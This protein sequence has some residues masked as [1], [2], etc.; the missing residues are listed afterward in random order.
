MTDY[1]NNGVQPEA[2]EQNPA[3]APQ[4]TDSTPHLTVDPNPNLPEIPDPFQMPE[5][6]HAPEPPKAEPAY[7]QP[8]YSAPQ[9][10][11]PQYSAPNYGQ[12][13]QYNV[14][15]QNP[16]VP[17][18][19]VANQNAATKTYYNVPPAGYVQKSRL[20]AGL[21]AILLGTFGVH[22]FSLGFKT[23]AIVQLIV[24]L[25]GSFITCGLAPIGIAIWALVEGILILS[26]SSP[27]RMYD[28]N[29]V[30]LRD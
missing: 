13:P 26:A 12:Q 1:E 3:A 21:L 15:P 8:Q 18:Y 10:S 14:P 5:P 24:S 23:R 2:T 17:Q 28:G 20:A 29:G 19:N 7:Q 22:N 27:A 30:I 9:Y 11:A 6:P 25:V 4:G 16:S